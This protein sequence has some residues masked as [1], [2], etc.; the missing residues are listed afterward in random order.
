M[1]KIDKFI[2]E[3]SAWHNRK[4]D[5]IRKEIRKLQQ[6]M[7]A[8]SDEDKKRI[9]TAAGIKGSKK[10]DEIYDYAMQIVDFVFKAEKPYGAVLYILA[11][12]EECAKKYAEKSAAAKEEAEL[13]SK[14]LESNA[15][16]DLIS[17]DSS[18]DKIQKKIDSLKEKSSKLN[19]ETSELEK[20]M[21]E[22]ENK[23][24]AIDYYKN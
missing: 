11:H 18:F 8:N 6:E 9:M 7:A 4:N 21:N 15:V 10:N 20:Q 12:L 5:D 16:S 19:S 1:K 14:I 3:M 13:L 24:P 23:Y 22:L 2:V 17:K